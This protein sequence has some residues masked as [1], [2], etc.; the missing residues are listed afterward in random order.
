M[1]Y[2]EE[3]PTYNSAVISIDYYMSCGKNAR[4]VVHYSLAYPITPPFR[5]GQHELLLRDL[6]D[7][8]ATLLEG[9]LPTEFFKGTVSSSPHVSRLRSSPSP[10]LEPRRPQR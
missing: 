7:L 6:D 9:D 2:Y 10:S 1:Q 4:V 8:L 3:P 5:Y